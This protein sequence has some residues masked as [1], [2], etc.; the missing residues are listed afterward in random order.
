MLGHNRIAGIQS[1]AAA[2]LQRKKRED[3]LIHQDTAD[4]EDTYLF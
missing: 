4:D 3:A 2:C 1:R